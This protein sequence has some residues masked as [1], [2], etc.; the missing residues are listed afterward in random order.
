MLPLPSFSSRL[1]GIALVLPA[2]LVVA[3]C[4]IA[5]LGL[6]VGG[7]FVSEQGIGGAN[8]V[9]ALTLYAPDILFTLLIVGVPT[10]LIGLFS[11]LIGGYLTLGENPRWVALLRWVYRWPLFIPFIVTGQILRTFLA[12]NGWLNGA[13]D[14]VGIVDITSANNWLD[15]RGIVFAFVWKQTPFVALLVSGTMASLDR[16]TM[17]SARNL[18]AG[19]LRI[20]FEIVVPQVWHTLLTG[21]ILSFVTMMSVLSV[22][23]MINAQSPTLLSANIAFR[24][25]AYGD[26]GVANALGA[27]SLLMTAVFAVIYLRISMREKA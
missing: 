27:I 21:L 6:S 4:F 14:M 24:I 18:G 8:F 5:P 20:L 10:L 17:E 13:L 9:T 16:G 7:A 22:P 12:K 11:V 25:N 2:L 3:L 15:W 19:R 1:A 26:Y 23:L